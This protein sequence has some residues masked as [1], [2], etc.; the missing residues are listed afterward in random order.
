MIVVE[1][2]RLLLVKHQH[3]ETG[4]VWWVPPG[5]GVEGG[6]TLFECARRETFEETGLSV[7]LDKIV[8]VREFVEPGCHHCELFLL[9]T[10]YTGTLTISNVAGT[11]IDEHYIKDVRFLSRKEVGQITVHPENLKD[12]FWED[13]ER[14][15]P[16][17]R[18]LGLDRSDEKATYV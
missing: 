13:S 7:E 6:E 12:E 8:Y 11:G 5:G 4:E 16:T 14:G 1:A 10:S 18:Y 3:P 2:G 17:T 15:F 9:C